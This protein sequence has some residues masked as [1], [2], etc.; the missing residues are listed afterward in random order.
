MDG[1]DRG[2][3]KQ[4][5]AM[6][7]PDFVFYCPYC[8]QKG[9]QQFKVGRSILNFNDFN[10]FSSPFQFTA[11]NGIPEKES[12]LYKYITQE[13]LDIQA[14]PRSTSL[15]SS[16]G[17]SPAVTPSPTTYTII[18][19]PVEQPREV[20]VA[21]VDIGQRAPRIFPEADRPEKRLRN[22][23]FSLGSGPGSVKKQK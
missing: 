6:S 3:L 13:T 7:K 14:P 1:I 9:G 20:G 10:G 17:T 22:D 12:L 2:C 11:I 19:Q 21:P 23:S 4:E 5:A 18:A 16:V 8:C 15:P